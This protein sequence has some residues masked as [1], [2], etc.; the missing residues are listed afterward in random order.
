MSSP[1]G[2]RVTD[3][4]VTFVEGRTRSW[5]DVE[6]LRQADGVTLGLGGN[7]YCFIPW[8]GVRM[9]TYTVAASHEEF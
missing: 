2:I 6:W 1:G 7:V 4:T 8:S 9:M 5:H 3:V